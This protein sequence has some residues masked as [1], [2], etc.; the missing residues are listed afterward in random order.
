MAAAPLRLMLIAGEPSGDVLGAELLQ[1]LAQHAGRPIEAFGVGGAAMAR[2]GHE[3]LFDMAELSV[4]GIAEVLPRLPVLQM[5][6]AECVALALQHQTGRTD[7]HR[8]SGFQFSRGASAAQICAGNS[9]HALCR[10]ADLGLAAR[11]GAQDCALCRSGAGAAAVRTAAIYRRG[12][13]RAALW[14]IRS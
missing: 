13:G 3:S 9:H 12:S 6:I 5:R 11:P 14:A 4:M 7:H 8:Q 10:A 1:A 2:A